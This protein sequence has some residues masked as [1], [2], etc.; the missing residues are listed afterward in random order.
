MIQ[1]IDNIQEGD[2]VV[3]FNIG[4]AQYNLW[5][6]AVRTKIG[7]L[8]IS[9]AQLDDLQPGEPVVFF[10]RKG[11]APGTAGIHRATSSPADVQE[12]VVDKTI[13]GRYSSGSMSSGL[14]G[15]AMNWQSFVSRHSQVEATDALTFDVIGVNVEG[16]EQI[17]LE[18]VT[19]DQDLSSIDANEFPYL[20]VVFKITDDIN[21]TAAQLDKWIVVYTPVAEGILLF[22]GSVEQQVLNE[23][24]IWTGDYGFVNISNK[25][26]SDS[27]TV[28]YDVFNQALHVSTTGQFKIKA[29]SPND[30]TKFSIDVP[31][32]GQGGLNDLN[33][34]ANPKILFE[35]YYDNNVLQLLDYLQVKQETINPVL[36][37][38]ID[39]RYIENGDLVSSNPLILIKVFDENKFILKTDTVG[40]KVYL[41]Y[42][43]DAEPCE[44]V[45]ILLTD[46]KVKWFPATASE[47]FRIEFRPA[48]LVNG[49]YILRVEAEDAR[50]NNSGNVP[51]EIKFM[52]ESE[53]ALKISDPYPNPVSDRVY[54]K[55]VISGDVV[56]SSFD[57]QILSVNGK[58][59]TYF[60]KENFTGLHTGTNELV[61]NGM[62]T[63][64]NA[65]PNGIYIYKIVSS[66]NGKPVEKIGKLVLLKTF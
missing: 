52:V 66:L 37:V 41:T 59:V 63:R 60:G 34:F 65:L 26:F 20:R 15:P 44:P 14:I 36:D 40:M 54:F 42:P 47:T 49:T 6:A 46:E 62:D 3:L 56:P 43:C 12:L 57:L 4:D 27:V 31:T 35:Q 33:V 17:L 28:R 9:V 2:S 10:G 64:G 19:G 1:Y 50:G 29:P 21:L 32:I 51:Y 61:W 39:G 24:E 7:E 30:T 11:S 18:D 23:G 25:A 58:E 55:V 48:N 8:G 5:P 38:S 45:R 53:S 13:T 22:N 16:E